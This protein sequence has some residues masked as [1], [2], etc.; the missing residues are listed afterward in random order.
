MKLVDLSYVPNEA[1]IAAFVL[2]IFVIIFGEIV[3]NI[4]IKKA[5]TEY[6]L[7]DLSQKGLDLIDVK[8]LRFSTG[9]FEVSWFYKLYPH[10]KSGP[11]RNRYYLRLTLEKDNVRKNV[12]ARVESISFFNIDDVT[13]APCLSHI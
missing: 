8:S 6:I 7:F 2:F 10:L 3:R 5:M 13:Y 9:D 11:L 1:L 12:T 4:V